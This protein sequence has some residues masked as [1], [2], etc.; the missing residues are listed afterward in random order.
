LFE[1]PGG[2]LLR[3]QVMPVETKQERTEEVLPEVEQRGLAA[4]LKE[5]GDAIPHK[6]LFCVLLGA[7]VALFCFYGNANLG[8]GGLSSSVF[9]WLQNIY[10]S[11][12]DEGLA[13]FIPLVVL[14]LMWWKRDELQAVEKRVWW[15]GMV[16]FALAVLL[17]VAGFV[18][19][20]ARVSLVAFAVGIYALMGALWGRQWLR[21]TFFPF[22]LLAFAIP[23]TADME[24][25]T[26]YLRYLATKLTVLVSGWAGITV[27]QEG[28]LMFDSA[29]RF[30]YNV[31]A[32]CSGLRSL[33][34]MLALSCVFG[35]VSFKSP[36]KR[37]LLILSAVP[38][39]IIGNV[40]RLLT[41][42]VAAEIGGQSAGNYVHHHWLFSLIPYLPAMVG[43]SLLARWLREDNAEP[44]TPEMKESLA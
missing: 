32:A 38:F 5:F 33:T 3:L 25:Y 23:A 14:G 26:L 6:L 24:T 19:Q 11:D 12:P 35:F 22:F 34:T 28:T 31:E 29:H 2:I 9:N 4:E 41:I 1:R 44:L 27:L 10:K 8:Y 7:W 17:H 20:Q 13:Q 16:A 18:V 37:A 40:C 15:P 39:A 36:W 30:Q 43:M 21:A 42:I